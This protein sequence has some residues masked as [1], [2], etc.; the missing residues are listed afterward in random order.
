MAGVDGVGA[1]AIDDDVFDVDD[2]DDIQPGNLRSELM[3]TKIRSFYKSLNQEPPEFIDPNDFEYKGDHLF[4][5]TDGESVQ[6]TTKPDP[7][8][9]LR[10]NTLKQRLSVRD[11]GRLDICT[12]PKT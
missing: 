5:K 9:F 3:K 10:K 2:M 8:K 6:L 1:A 7:T 4:L 11:Q 12:R